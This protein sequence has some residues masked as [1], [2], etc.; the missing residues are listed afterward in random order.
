MVE[1]AE[2]LTVRRSAPYSEQFTAA[3]GYLKSDKPAFS[4]DH[5]IHGRNVRILP[6]A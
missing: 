4:L 2:R 6:P 3:S 5:V 1:I